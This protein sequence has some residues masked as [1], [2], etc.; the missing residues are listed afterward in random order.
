MFSII[1]IISTLVVFKQLNY[2]LKASLGYDR[3]HVVNIPYTAA[4]NPQFESFRNDLLRN[5]AVKNMTRSSRIPTGRLLDALGTSISVADTLQPLNITLKFIT[6]DYEFIPTYGIGMKAGRNFSRNFARDSFNYVINESAIKLLGFKTP[7]DAIGKVIG[8]GG[9]KGEIIG[10]NKDFHFESMHQ[11]IVPL[12]MRMPANNFGG[13][14]LLSVKIA[15]NNDITSAINLIQKTWYRYLPDTPFMY[16]FLDESYKQLY[17][18]EQRQGDI[19]TLFACIAIL[20]A[21][22]GLFGLSAFSITQRTKEIGVRKVL[23]ASVSNIVSL[24]SMDFIKLVLVSAVIAFPIAWYAMHTWLQDFAY[25][26]AINWWI[27]VIAG[28]TALLIALLTVSFQAVK[29]AVANPV[30]SLRTE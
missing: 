22:L 3:E 19:F 14:G 29:A 18:A 1:L 21:C 10:V 25:R 4:L 2:M 8:Y 11:E 15:R 12:L 20:I 24:L 23:G 27:F 28:I 7:V 9:V 17:E 26:I 30:K 5:P 13:Y 16:T 6:V